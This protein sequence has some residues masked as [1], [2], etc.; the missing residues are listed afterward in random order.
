MKAASADSAVASGILASS[1]RRVVRSTSMPT[2][3]AIARSLDQVSFPVPGHDPVIDLRWTHMDADHL[4][5]LPASILATRARSARVASLAQT[6]HP[7]LA[8]LALGMR[9]DGVVDGL[10]R[11]VSFR[12]IRPHPAQCPGNLARRPQPG[13]QMRDN[14]PQGAIGMRLGKRLARLRRANA[15]CRADCEALLLRATSRLTELG[16]RSSTFA[17]DRRLCPC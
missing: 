6:G 10:V 5:D 17:I 11:D 8:Q 14:A 15:A 3:G 1:T 2:L 9:I 16:L 7:R 12:V 13:Q 4:R